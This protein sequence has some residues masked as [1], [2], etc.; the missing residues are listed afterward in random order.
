MEGGAGR[1]SV[2]AD[3]REPGSRKPTAVQ[4]NGIQSGAYDVRVL[5]MPV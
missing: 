5:L 2:S 3:M 4:R 1:A